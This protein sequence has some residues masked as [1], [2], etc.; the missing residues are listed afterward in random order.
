MITINNVLKCA[1]ISCCSVLAVSC[2]SE[3]SVNASSDLVERVYLVSDFSSISTKTQANVVITTGGEFS[4]KAIVPSNIRDYFV[5]SKVGDR[6]IV[7]NKNV[8][9]KVHN[10]E[11]EP[12]IYVTMPSLKAV[13]ASSQS[14]VSVSGDVTPEFKVTATGQSDVYF[15]NP[16]SVSALSAS[17]SNQ[18]EIEFGDVRAGSFVVD[19]SGQSSMEWDNA[20]VSADAYIR[21]S[22]QSSVEFES[23][24]AGDS[25]DVRSSSQSSIEGEKLEAKVGEVHAKN[26]SSIKVSHTCGAFNSSSSGQ[27]S[28]SLNR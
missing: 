18:S 6:L 22:G 21:A 14:E 20:I 8:N 16:L 24:L 7:S 4:V 1:A 10:K 15:K 17:A 19:A 23:V 5:L 2:A 27:S 9:L 28:C 3:H 25:V 26:Q 13:E 12:V 11:N